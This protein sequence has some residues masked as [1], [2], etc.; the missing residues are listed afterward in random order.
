MLAISPKNYPIAASNEPLRG[1]EKRSFFIVRPKKS[2]LE[3]TVSPI[4]GEQVRRIFAK[5]SKPAS[6]LAQNLLI[7]PDRC[8]VG[9]RH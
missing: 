3:L 2:K 6:H 7:I 9:R 8:G 5:A 1:S 4:S